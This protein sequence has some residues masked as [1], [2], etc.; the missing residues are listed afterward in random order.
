MAKPRLKLTKR[1]RN[2]ILF[3]AALLIASVNTGNNLLYLILSFMISFLLFSF[4]APRLLFNGVDIDIKL[5]SCLYAG[6]KARV[7]VKI[8]NKK[9]YLPSPPFYLKAL[10]SLPLLAPPF[11]PSVLGGEDYEELMIREVKRRGLY[12]LKGLFAETGYPFGLFLSARVVPAEVNE[13]VV[14]P[15]VFPLS[16]FIVHGIPGDKAIESLFKGRSMSLRNIRDYAYGDEVRFLH[17]KASAKLSRLMVKEFCRKEELK[18][19]IL[20]P[21][22]VPSCFSRDDF[23]SRVSFAASLASYL[24]GRNYFVRLVTSHSELPLGIGG[25]QLHKV[26]RE[27]AIV[28]PVA[29]AAEDLVEKELLVSEA[30]SRSFRVLVADESYPVAKDAMVMPLTAIKAAFMVEIGGKEGE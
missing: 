14:Y 27:L 17:W 28:E 16:S 22:I 23:E 6:E 24:I 2:H 29:K 26:L 25:I 13:F 30:P 11:L 12:R 15:R 1:G 8:E 7:R 10:G 4:I 3:I 18:V 19:T 9:R 20:L 21:T 5:P